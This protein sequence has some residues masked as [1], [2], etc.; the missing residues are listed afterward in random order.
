MM[1]L[2]NPKGSVAI[3]LVSSI[4]IILTLAVLY[5]YIL[6]NARIDAMHGYKD[7]FLAYYLCETGIS[8]AML[9]FGQGKIGNHPRRQ[10]TARNLDFEI[11]GKDYAIYYNIT[12]AEGS[13]NYK[14]LSMVKSP[15]GLDRTYYMTAAG[16]R[17]FPLYIRGFGGAGGK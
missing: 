9:D 2:R 16:P 15:L 17:A 3:M 6:I 11:D 10:W 1:K 5:L 4:T 14:I 12:K 7:R 8:I 13:P